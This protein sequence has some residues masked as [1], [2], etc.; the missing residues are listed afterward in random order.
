MTFPP[1][2]SFLSH[3]Q[4]E[5]DPFVRPSLDWDHHDLP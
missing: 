5:V 4:M 3:L 1:G 2:F